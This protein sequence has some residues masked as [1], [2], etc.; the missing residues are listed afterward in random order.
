MLCCR[1]VMLRRKSVCFSHAGVIFTGHAPSPVDW[2]SYCASSVLICEHKSNSGRGRLTKSVRD[3]C[4]QKLVLAL[5]VLRYVDEA[6][7]S[8]CWKWLART[9]VLIAV[10][11]SEA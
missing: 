8:P 5:V 6:V 9:G 10:V 11:E 4:S 2:R 7:L 3:S 1:I